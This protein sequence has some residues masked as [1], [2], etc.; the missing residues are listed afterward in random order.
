[1]RSQLRRA[2]EEKK[3]AEVEKKVSDDALER[4]LDHLDSEHQALRV[5][6]EA[7]K[8]S[9]AQLAQAMEE[10][11]AMKAL[12]AAREVKEQPSPPV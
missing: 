4:V 12:L 6:R 2:N 11:G 8:A 5:A 9:K 10:M 7:T 1:M 3:A